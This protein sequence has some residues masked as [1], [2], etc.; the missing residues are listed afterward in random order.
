MVQKRRV[1][2][3]RA[4]GRHVA[5]DEPR[6]TRPQLLVL[7]PE[8]GGEPGAHVGQDD[9]GAAEERLE[10]L[11][12][13]AMAQIERQ[14]VLAAVADQEVPALAATEG[15]DVAARLALERLDLDH[16][17]AAVGKDLPRPRHRDE[18]TELD[19]GDAGERPL[20]AHRLTPA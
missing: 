7:E 10:D 9:V 18:V 14:R 4:E 3:A 17:G 16:V 15:R 12:R 6:M 8:L 2:P 1:G 5:D 11:A 20:G 19:D 13:V